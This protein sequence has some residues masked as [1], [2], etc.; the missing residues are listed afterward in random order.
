VPGGTP[1]ARETSGRGLQTVV[2]GESTRVADVPD[3]LVLKRH[4]DFIG[5][6]FTLWPR[7]SI[8]GLLAILCLLGLLNVFGQHPSAVSAETPAAKLT[9]S[10]PTKLR[11]GLLFS[12]R[13]HITAHRELKDAT[14]VLDPGWAEGMAINTIEPSPLG[15]GSRNGRMTLQLGH[16]PAGES[17]ILFMQFQVNPTTVAWQRPQNVELDDGDTKVLTINRDVVI[18][19]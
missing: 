4:R 10:A 17:Y 13:F 18:Y 14:L 8:I 15:E 11:G 6:R 1:A 16:V 19:P 5:R 2:N 9:L 12:A 7:W 3:T